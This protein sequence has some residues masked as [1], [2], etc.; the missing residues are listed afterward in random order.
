VSLNSS[1]AATS[2]QQLLEASL[3]AILS[4]VPEQYAAICQAING[5]SI[6]LAF[7]NERFNL[8][9]DGIHIHLHQTQEPATLWLKTSSYAVESVI[10]QRLDLVDGVLSEAI[11]VRGEMAP[12]AQFNHA[13]TQYVHGAVRSQ[14]SS[15]ILRQF[16]F[17]A[18]RRHR[19]TFE[20]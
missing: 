13:L 8:R 15:E 7:D 11:K 19:E 5:I 2:V 18:K 10:D 4:D 20:G 14:R 1:A 12:L 16:R 17:L 9:S 6:S 3:A